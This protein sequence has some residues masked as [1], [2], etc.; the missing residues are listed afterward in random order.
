MIDE[1][2]SRQ[3]AFEEAEALCGMIGHENTIEELP[4]LIA[5]PKDRAR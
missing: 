1:L 2:L 5:V 4:E 3:S